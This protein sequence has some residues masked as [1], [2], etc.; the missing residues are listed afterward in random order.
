MRYT[1]AERAEALEALRGWIRPGDEVHCIVR[2]VARSGMSRDISLV[3]LPIPGRKGRASTLWISQSVGAVIGEPP[4]RTRDHDAIHVVGCGMDMC[5]ATVYALA[6]A[7]FRD[8]PESKR[9][10]TAPRGTSS[11]GY[12]LRAGSL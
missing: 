11:R 3:L 12:W 9:P 4:A 8:A 7:L 2:R 10:A 5:F 6:E 1:K